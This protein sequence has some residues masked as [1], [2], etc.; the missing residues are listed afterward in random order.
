MMP[1]AY[2]PFFFKLPHQDAP[3]TALRL[4]IGFLGD[5]DLDIGRLPV[6]LQSPPPSKWQAKEQSMGEG[7]GR[8]GEGASTLSGRKL[9]TCALSDG[10][11]RRASWI[12]GDHIDSRRS[13][14]V[15]GE[16][17]LGPKSSA[18]QT[19]EQVFN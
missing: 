17:P 8:Q 10:L 13:V 18:H 15:G 19:G 5:L 9:K 6:V 12:S 1:L 2:Q 11:F 16:R 14:G 7:S 4:G 3:V